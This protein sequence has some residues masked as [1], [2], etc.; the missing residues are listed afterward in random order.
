MVLSC[1]TLPNEEEIHESI[2]DFQ[3]TGGHKGTFQNEFKVYG[4]N[5]LLC[6]RKYCKGK[7]QKV[8]VSSRSTFYCN[9]CQK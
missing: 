1:A 8:F 7:I 4:K 6:S 2:R 9:I 5:G 3:N